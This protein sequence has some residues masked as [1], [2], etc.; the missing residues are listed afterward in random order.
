MRN[1][2]ARYA[3][4]HSLVTLKGWSIFGRTPIEREEGIIMNKVQQRKSS[5]RLRKLAV[6]RK[7]A[8]KFKDGNGQQ[9]AKE[10]RERALA[11]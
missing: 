3:T 6:I 4:R 9:R 11:K 1:C 10:A 5:H 7:E 8:G 2:A